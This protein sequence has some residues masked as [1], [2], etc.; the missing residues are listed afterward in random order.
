MEIIDE[1]VGK[2]LGSCKLTKKI[3][4]GGMGAVYL[5]HHI[6][7]DKKV[8]VKILPPWFSQDE[9]RI[10]RFI[11]E[12]RSTA[13]LEH[14]NIIQVYDI[15]IAKPEGFYFIVMQYV[16]GESLAM[17]IKRRGKIPVAEATRII[18]DAARALTAAHS[19][20]VIH[21]DVKAENIMINKQG[22]VKLMDFGLARIGSSNS[23]ISSPG[24]VLGTPHY[25]APEQARGETVDARSDIYSLGA[26]YYY[27]LTGQMPFD[28]T[29]PVTVIM[30]HLNE[31]LPNPCKITP[32]IPAKVNSTLS[33]MMAKDVKKRYQSTQELINDFDNILT[34][35]PLSSIDTKTV[36][37]TPAPTGKINKWNPLLVAISTVALLLLV[38]IIVLAINKNKHKP[39]NLP[40]QQNARQMFEET[41]NYLQI[42]PMDYEKNIANFTAI[43]QNYPNTTET[44]KANT[45][46]RHL[47]SEYG[48]KLRCEAFCNDLITG[49]DKETLRDYFIPEITN[50]EFHEVMVNMERLRPKAPEIKYTIDKIDLKPLMNKSLSADVKITWSILR[51]DRT[52][53]IETPPQR[54]KY[55]QDKWY[56]IP[57]PPRKPL[58]GKPTDPTEEK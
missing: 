46:I 12:A 51:K 35:L 6:S 23:S 29:T 43:I 8:A 7:L 50:E 2:T 15:K 24:N 44:L 33:K 34:E 14:P 47:K 41:K 56:I 3:G 38:L 36:K 49:K 26:T 13:Q 52:L 27:A 40:N 28:G 11:R 17:A 18:R 1:F 45:I 5:A 32:E 10:K 21:R 9:E 54:W 48:L 20:G 37:V 31:P 22:E 39:E 16:D 58:Q 19:H 57:I 53:T 42:H 25:M 30:K 55:H 4:E